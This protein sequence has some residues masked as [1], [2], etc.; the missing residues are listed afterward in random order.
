MSLFEKK[1]KFCTTMKYKERKSKNNTFDVIKTIAYK[2]TSYMKHCSQLFDQVDSF[3]FLLQCDI[4]VDKTPVKL[5]N[6][7]QTRRSWPLS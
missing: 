4:S 6:H 5:A 7:E 2:E 3:R 1:K